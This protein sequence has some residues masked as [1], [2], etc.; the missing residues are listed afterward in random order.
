MI[1]ASSFVVALTAAANECAVEYAKQGPCDIDAHELGLPCAWR[2][3]KCKDLKWQHATSRAPIRCGIRAGNMKF[4]ALHWRTQRRNASSPCG[5]AGG[6]C[7]VRLGRL[8]PAAVPAKGLDDDASMAAVA[9][10]VAALPADASRDAR[11]RVLLAALEAARDRGFPAATKD[12]LKLLKLRHRVLRVRG[13][14][15]D[16]FWVRALDVISQATW[17]RLAGK[18]VVAQFTWK[19]DSYVSPGNGSGWEA[20]FEPLDEP[21]APDDARLELDCDLIRRVYPTRASAYPATRDRAR[22][23]RALRAAQVAAFVRPNAHVLGRVDA[24]WRR[25]T[26]GEAL[27]VLG[28][29]VRGT[30]KRSKHRAIVPPER[31][32]PL[33]DAYLARPNAKVFLA[34][35]DAKFRR[36]FA[37]RYGAALLEQAGVA[38]VKGA[39]FAGGAD[40]D[41]FARGLAV[42]AD[43][44]LLAK[45]AF[46]LKSASAVSEFALYFRPD[47]PSFDFDVADDAVP[48]W[49]PAAFNATTPG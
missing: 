39:A 25:L 47:L 13:S 30:D 42:L 32:F 38:R 21:Y 33:V 11:A 46:L 20:F 36:R 4:I 23:V 37:D 17:A 7:V 5:A 6:E 40:A 19:V 2:D 29:H 18:A 27:D 43:T 28:V 48:A 8:P 9:T 24:E 35:D 44:L 12:A 1:R 3:G 34:T 10:A 22:R 26:R 45:C 14:P 41:G 16:G 15:R 31:Y 49:A